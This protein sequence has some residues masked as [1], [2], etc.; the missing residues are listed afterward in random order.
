MTQMTKSDDQKLGIKILDAWASAIDGV[1]DD[2]PDITG[3]WLLKAFQVKRAQ[4]RFLPDRWA[5]PSGQQAALLA[6]ES[7]TGALEHPQ[8][9]VLTSI[10]MPNEIF[11]SLGL[12]PLIA[13]AAANFVT[14]AHA[15][16]SFIESAEKHGVP[17]TYCSFHKV[18]LGGAFAEVF[19]S[20]PFIA[21]CSVA[22]DA[23]NLS[24]KLLAAHYGAPQ[25]YIDVPDSYTEENCRYVAEQLESLAH[26]LEEA[27]GRTLDLEDLKERVARSQRTLDKLAATLP[28]RRNRFVKNNMGLEMQHAL[29]FHTLLGD[30]KAEQLAT[31]MLEDYADAPEFHGVNLVWSATAPFF[32]VPL[33]KLVDVN[34][35]QQIITSDM[36]FDQVTFDGWHH[37]GAHEPFLAMAERLIR[38]SYNGGGQHRADRMAELCEM[39]KADGAVVFCHWG[40]KETMGCAQLVKSTLER[41]DFPCITLDGDGCNRANFP[42]G[43]A[44]TRLGAFLEMLHARK[45]QRSAAHP[46]PAASPR[47]ESDEQTVA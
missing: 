42:G 2:R 18:L 8:D 11:Q 39:T 29:V 19:P 17:E 28:L 7:V 47:D 24:F 21:N 13:E 43:Q 32:S 15:E 45:D 6:L 9:I 20:I 5:H 37:D 10:F 23:N 35:E 46:Q 22:C 30:P 12:Y 4:C 33:Q 41:A 44:A 40:C 16:P 36:C 27:Y 25:R 38:N 31:Q 3:F 26:A 1:M 34:P 14:G